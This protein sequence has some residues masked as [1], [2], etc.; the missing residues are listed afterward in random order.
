MRGQGPEIQILGS[1]GQDLHLVPSAWA[2]PQGFCW[3]PKPGERR[4]RRRT[5]HG[6]VHGAD[7]QIIQTDSLFG[8]LFVEKDMFERVTDNRLL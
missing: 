5:A 1:F 2:A 7:I 3:A 8:F 6:A 4:G